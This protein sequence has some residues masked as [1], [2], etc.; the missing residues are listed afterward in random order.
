MQPFATYI[1][2]VLSNPRRNLPARSSTIRTESSFGLSFTRIL[3]TSFPKPYKVVRELPMNGYGVADLV[4]LTRMKSVTNR[5]MAFEFKISNWRKA[6]SQA[7]RY[8]YFANIAIV[9]M[10]MADA[11]KALTFLP[12][13]RTLNVGLWAFDKASGRIMKYYTPRYSRP[14]HSKAKLKA[15]M[16]L[17]SIPQLNF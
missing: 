15:L 6:L 9:V 17:D 3:L 12:T 11:K 2:P 14:L 8:R 10:P 5:L 4:C 7:Y 16:Q 1:P 13:F